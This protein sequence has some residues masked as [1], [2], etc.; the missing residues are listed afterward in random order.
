M[1][2]YTGFQLLDLQPCLHDL[3][4]TF[5]LAPKHAQKAVREK[6]QSARWDYCN[7]W[8]RYIDLSVSHLFTFFIPCNCWQLFP[9][10]LFK[11]VWNITILRKSRGRL[12]IIGCHILG[13]QSPH[14]Y[15]KAFVQFVFI[16]KKEKYMWLLEGALLCESKLLGTA[17]KLPL[18]CNSFSLISGF[19][20]YNTERN[21]MKLQAILNV[22]VSSINEYLHGLHVVPEDTSW[23][24]SRSIS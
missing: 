12:W 16:F 2:H 22:D 5:S 11:N 21:V 7:S 24:L 14:S 19:S 9:D 23:W 18:W 20:A 3:H 4:R 17:V 13:H 15:L 6:Y 1:C 10:G 8:P